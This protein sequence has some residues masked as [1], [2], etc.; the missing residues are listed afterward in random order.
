MRTRTLLLLAAACGLVI[1][2]A[3]GLKL[4]Q[5]ATD[6]DEVEALAWGRETVIGDMT[7]AVDAIDAGSTG[8]DTL[9]DTLDITVVTVRLGGVAGADALA[10]WRLW[11]DGATPRRPLESDERTTC[12]TLDVPAVG[13]ASCDIAFESVATVQG[14][15]YVRAGEQRQWS[16]RAP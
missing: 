9:D 12:D 15:I 16:G 5:V 3:G 11:A 10:G 4:F 8:D 14:V 7:V 6:P 2:L 13:T 1:L